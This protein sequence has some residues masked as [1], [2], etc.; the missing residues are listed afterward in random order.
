MRK[1]SAIK[2][3]IAQNSSYI[4]RLK[5][6]AENMKYTAKTSEKLALFF[7]FILLI[8]MSPIYFLVQ[9]MMHSDYL[10]WLGL[11]V[12]IAWLG[13]FIGYFFA[14]CSTFA[15]ISYS[16][17]KGSFVFWIAVFV[18]NVTSLL[19]FFNYRLPDSTI[20]FNGLFEMD[21]SV[22]ID[23][24]TFPIYFVNDKVNSIVLKYWVGSVFI[25]AVPS[26]LIFL[27][28]MINV[29]REL[30][31]RT[32]CNKKLKRIKAAIS[33]KET[34]VQSLNTE[35][36][37]NIEKADNIYRTE[38][39]KDEPNRAIMI[40]AAEGGCADA[41][42]WV[43]LEL[44][45]ELIA[46]KDNLSKTKISSAAQKI[47]DYIQLAN[48][49]TQKDLHTA[50]DVWS[51]VYEKQIGLWNYAFSR[52]KLNELK[53]K[54]DKVSKLTYS[55]NGLVSIF[56]KEADCDLREGIANAENVLQKKEAE[57]ANKIRNER[58]ASQSHS[59]PV[60]GEPREERSFTQGG[61]TGC[62]IGG[63]FCGCGAGR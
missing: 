58:I 30:L 37:R 55:K 38:L 2:Q 41:G 43:A 54:K 47:Q 4:A 46:D 62:G 34:V 52:D 60:Y 10:S 24:S 48:G 59:Y 7:A 13:L 19:L 56:A 23:K 40:Q 50:L 32:S 49:C 31:K 12:G 20:R 16:A 6:D 33:E 53:D 45:Q 39:Q 26:F 35:A 3:E 27:S 14:V 21:L 22:Y 1:I 44:A 57:E 9:R 15:E 42:L 17:A 11:F 5:N 61:S 28:M 63:S 8:A 36:A 51:F 29:I 18:A 25:S